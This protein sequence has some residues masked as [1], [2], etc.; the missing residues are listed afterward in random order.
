LSSIARSEQSLDI[1]LIGMTDDEHRSREYQKEYKL[2]A[3]PL[4]AAPDIA[5]ELRIR[6]AP[7]GIV[8]NDKGVVISK[9]V[10]NHMEHLENLLN[11]LDQEIS[12]YQSA[13]AVD[14]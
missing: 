10:A 2:H 1:V 13:M 8:A 7:Y 12:S 4:L 5:A 6:S 11:A 14:A 3:I 9:G